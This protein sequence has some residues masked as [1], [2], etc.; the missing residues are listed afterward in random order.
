MKTHKTVYGTLKGKNPPVV[1]IIAAEKHFCSLTYKYQRGDVIL[2]Y[3]LNEI[4]GMIRELKSEPIT[5]YNRISLN[6][7]YKPSNILLKY[8]IKEGFE[9][10]CYY[11]K[12]EK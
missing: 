9:V 1:Y 5:S 11:Q 12:P 4:P 2:N 7:Y 10:K 8:F 6:L 3:F